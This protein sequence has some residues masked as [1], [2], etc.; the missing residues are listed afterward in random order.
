[1]I[2]KN[3]PYPTTKTKTFRTRHH[4]Q[5]EVLIRILYGEHKLAD[6]NFLLGQFRLEGIRKAP[7]GHPIDIRYKLDGNYIFTATAKD[8]DTGTENGMTI[9]NIAEPKFT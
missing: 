5:T 3:T 4:N 9:K 6:Q 8:K 1:M 2:E 7:R